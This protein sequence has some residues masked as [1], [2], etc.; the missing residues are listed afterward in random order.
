MEKR[1]PRRVPGA[2][3]TWDVRDIDAQIDADIDAQIHA[4][5]ERLLAMT[6][7]Q[8]RADLRAAGVAVEERAST[9]GRA[10]N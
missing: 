2:I 3:D 5:M 9:K 10:L 4:E 6:P 1:I 7:E 8:R